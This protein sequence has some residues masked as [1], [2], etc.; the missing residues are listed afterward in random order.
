V[1]AVELDLELAEVVVVLEQAHFQQYQAE[2][3]I[4]FQ[5][6]AEVPVVQAAALTPEQ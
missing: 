3:C 5:L 1:V 2:F 4:L 6:V